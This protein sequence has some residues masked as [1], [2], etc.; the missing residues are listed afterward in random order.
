MYVF[1]GDYQ[2]IC[3]AFHPSVLKD[4]G[5]E[6]SSPEE[7]RML[8]HLAL[9]YINDAHKLSLSRDYSLLSKDELCKG[10]LKNAQES[11]TR[12]VNNSQENDFHKELGDLEEMFGPMATGCKDSLLKEM[13]NIT[14]SRS[15]DNESSQSEIEP[16]TL[17]PEIKMP[18]SAEGKKKGLIEEVPNHTKI[19]SEPQHSVQLK[20]DGLL[21]VKIKLPGICSVAD[22]QL[23]ISQVLTCSYLYFISL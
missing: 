20:E 11:L 2:T 13:S 16:S 17:E 9:S 19:M 8:I 21:Q 12:N 3:V 7:Q 14:A 22:C 15:D 6:C 10:L 23:D 18:F 1:P 4:F 5:R